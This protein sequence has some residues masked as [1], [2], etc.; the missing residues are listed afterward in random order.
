MCCAVGSCCPAAACRADLSHLWGFWG[1][2]GWFLGERIAMEQGDRCFL[3]VG[4]SPASL[5]WGPPSTAKGP[6]VLSHHRAAPG[7]RPPSHQPG[8]GIYSSLVTCSTSPGYSG[9]TEGVCTHTEVPAHLCSPA[10]FFFCWVR[11]DL[12]SISRKQLSCWLFY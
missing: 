11:N 1:A 8:S 5:L 3:V 2:V 4:R 12:Q 10:T 6:C 7:L 9:N